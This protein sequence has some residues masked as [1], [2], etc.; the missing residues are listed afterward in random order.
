MRRDADKRQ[1]VHAPVM[2]RREIVILSAVTAGFETFPT[3]SGRFLLQ[4]AGKPHAGV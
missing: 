4:S 1:G 2:A 3:A